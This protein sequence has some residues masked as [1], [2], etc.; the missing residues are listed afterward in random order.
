MLDE[1]HLMARMTPTKGM[2]M[3]A[4]TLPST[5]AGHAGRFIDLIGVARRSEEAG[6]YVVR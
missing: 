4:F 1:L 6:G 3:E 2:N 5:D